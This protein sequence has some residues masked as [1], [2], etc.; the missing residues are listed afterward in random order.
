LKNLKITA[1]LMII[2]AAMLA[3]SCSDKKPPVADSSYANPELWEILKESDWAAW[4]GGT[5]CEMKF[6]GDDK[7]IA[8]E[9]F[10]DP[11]T[12]DWKRTGSDFGTVEF[13]DENWFIVHYNNKTTAYFFSKSDST[14]EN[15]NGS[16]FRKS[17]I[18]AFRIK[19]K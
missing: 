18:N 1:L 14:F 19:K 2:L 6:V 15:S 12:Q 4:A 13:L 7:A 16:S 8:M 10:Q 5:G 3:I 9:W 11:V 17:Q